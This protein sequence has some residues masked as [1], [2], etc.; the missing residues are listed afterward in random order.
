MKTI[1]LTWA[2]LALAGLSSLHA[3]TR[4][5]HAGRWAGDEPAIDGIIS[6]EGWEGAIWENDFI[7][8]NPYEGEDPSQQT[9]FKILYDNDNLYVAIRAFDSEPHLVE[10]RMSRRDDIEGDRVG[11]EIDSYFD[12]RTSFNFTV[13]AAGVKKDAIITDDVNPDASWNPVWYVKVSTDSL[14]WVAEMKIPYSQLR[15][16]KKNEYIWGLQVFRIIHRHDEY[17]AWQHIPVES[18]GWVSRYGLLE[19]IANILP[20]KEVEL[21]PYVM[22]NTESY[23]REEGNPFATGRDFG[24]SAG[25]DAKVA[26]TNDLTLNVSVNPDFGQVEADPSEVNLTGLETYFREKRPFFVEGSNIYSFNLTTGDGGMS[27]DNL[28]YS[29]RIGRSPHHC[30][31]TEEGQYLDFPGSTR[32]LGAAKLSGKTRNGWSIGILESVTNRETATIDSEGSR[33]RIGVEPLTNYFNT[34]VQKDF[35]KGETIIG[36]M[37]TATNRFINDSSLSDIHRAA[38]TGGIDFTKYWKDRTYYLDFKGVFSH[39]TG[40]RE[41]ILALQEAPQR[42]FQRPDATH[43]SIDPSRTSL[44][45]HGGTV[46]FGKRGEGHWRYLAYV[47]WRSPGL[48][49]NDMGYLRQGDLVQQVFWVGYRIWEPFSIFRNANFNFNQ[50][51]GWDFSGN[52]FFNGANISANVQ[53]K[54][55][56]SFGTGTGWASDGVNRSGLRGGPLMKT[57]GHWNN[58]FWISSDDR[59][60]F[61]AQLSGFNLWGDQNTN[62]WF[63]LGLNL[64]YRPIVSLSVSMGPS[65][66]KSHGVYQYVDKLSFLGEDRYIV[67][68]IDQEMLMANIRI[69]FSITPDLSIQFW[70][71]PFIFACDYSEFKRVTQPRAGTFYGQFHQFTPQEISFHSED[72]VYHVDENV[73]GNMDY[74]FNNPDFKV[75]EFRS[76]LVLRWEYI[77]GSTLYLVWSQGRSDS[78]SEGFFNLNHDMRDIF[79]VFP[80]DIFLVK[81]TYR[82]S[83]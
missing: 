9:T 5:C 76:N 10:R 14:G 24:Y 38:Y 78:R 1:L 22:A 36:G 41:S 46:E 35:N 53:F 56:W 59:K 54:N 34:R 2:I 74:S 51:T 44:T 37:F 39:V 60:K 48:E 82:L 19:G 7:Q 28:F 40:N 69:N 32:I 67:A 25:L 3:Q 23:M 49:L 81:L 21:V 61:V 65:Y 31:G 4:T 52:N 79:N 12:K 15:F 8:R 43:V 62:R 58:W 18:S 83:F 17:S 72:D 42:Y 57:E 30:P 66:Q 75:F 11:I 33:E 63:D 73:D 80:H 29:R 64:S 26:V 47:T 50:W 68:R 13:N 16:A 77:P 20:K 27:R 55:F 45:G 71:Q 70:G 6:E